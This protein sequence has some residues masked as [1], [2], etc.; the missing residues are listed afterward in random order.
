[1]DQLPRVMTPGPECFVPGDGSNEFFIGAEAG[2][3]YGV[4]V[5]EESQVLGVENVSYTQ[6]SHLSSPFDLGLSPGRNAMLLPV[7]LKIWL[8]KLG[9]RRLWSEGLE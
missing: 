2:P 8:S 1:M 7:E 5:A 3:H 4:P 9:V 6:M